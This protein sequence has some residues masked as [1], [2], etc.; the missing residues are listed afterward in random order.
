MIV[1]QI[2]LWTLFVLMSLSKWLTG[3]FHPAFLFLLA[4]ISTIVIFAS[5]PIDLILNL[6]FINNKLTHKLIVYTRVY[7]WKLKN[8]KS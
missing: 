6:L 2:I 1:I 5:I 3:K 8:S 7:A 4:V